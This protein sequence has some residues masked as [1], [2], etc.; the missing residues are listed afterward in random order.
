MKTHLTEAERLILQCASK[1]AAAAMS[2]IYAEHLE[3]FGD[4]A[5]ESTFDLH[6]G[7]G[8]VSCNIEEALLDDAMSE[9][10]AAMRNLPY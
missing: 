7:L 3:P 6:A 10:E 2:R 1:V 4:I 5:P 9:Q 8:L